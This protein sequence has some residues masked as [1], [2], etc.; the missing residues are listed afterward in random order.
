MDVALQRDERAHRRRRLRD[1]LERN[2]SLVIAKSAIALTPED[3]DAVFEA[4][5]EFGV[6][7]L[8]RRLGPGPDDPDGAA[9]PAPAARAGRARAR[10]APRPGG[11]RVGLRRNAAPAPGGPAALPGP[12]H[13]HRRAL[14][15]PLRRGPR[16]G[17]RRARD[18]LRGAGRRGAR[19]GRRDALRRRDRPSLSDDRPCARLHHQ[20][21][22][23]A[24]SRRLGARRGSCSAASPGCTPRPTV[25]RSRTSGAARST[26]S[27]SWTRPS[28]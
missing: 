22:R 19:P 28:R 5:L 15:S 21:A 20:V 14:V 25:R 26:W 2:I 1:G 8:G 24:R 27:R 4:G 10:A 6:R 18:R 7:G 11:G 3:T 12:R 16:R 13:R 17:G 23:G 9:Q